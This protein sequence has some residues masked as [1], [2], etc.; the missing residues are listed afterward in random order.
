MQSMCVSDITADMSISKV[1]VESMP[2]TIVYIYL[3]R[4]GCLVYDFKTI[5]KISFQEIEL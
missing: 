3:H 2:H 5:L 1:L 4:T